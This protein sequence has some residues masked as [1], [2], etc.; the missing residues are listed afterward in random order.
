MRTLVCICKRHWN[1]NNNSLAFGR[2][3]NMPIRKL[4]ITIGIYTVQ[5]MEEMDNCNVDKNYDKQCY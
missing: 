3:F 5:I 2:S 4:R 1:I